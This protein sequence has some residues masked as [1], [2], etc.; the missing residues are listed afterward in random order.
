MTT[1]DP[2]KLIQANIDNLEA[3]LQNNRNILSH[4]SVDSE[5]YEVIYSLHLE[6]KQD[7]KNLETLLASL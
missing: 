2:K 4:L 7:K 5:E 1:E 6:H 3:M